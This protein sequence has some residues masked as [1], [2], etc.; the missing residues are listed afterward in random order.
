[1]KR[2]RACAKPAANAAVCP[3]LRRN[4]ITRSRGSGACS[5]ASSSNVSSVL[6]SSIDDDLVA[7][8]RTPSSAAVSS[9]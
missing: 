1:M 9:R 4:R 6:P 5:A 8:G 3:K 7:S 2:P